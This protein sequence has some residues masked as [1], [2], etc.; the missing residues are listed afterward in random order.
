M[1][2]SGWPKN[3]NRCCQ[4]RGD[5]P[6][7]RSNTWVPKWR[8]ESRRTEAAVSTGKAIS[9]SPLV[10]SMFQV[11]MG[12]RNMVIPGARIPTMVVMRLT[13]V[14]TA[15]NPVSSKPISHSS[16]PMLGE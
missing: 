11:K 3:Q 2:T 13:A 14:N 16:P 9:T 15:E 12:T 8:S 7:R 1:Y 10:T 4:S 5:P 6:K